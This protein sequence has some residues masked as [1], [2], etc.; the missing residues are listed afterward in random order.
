MASKRVNENQHLNTNK[1]S[2]STIS[3]PLSSSLTPLV[4]DEPVNPRDLDYTPVL[5]PDFF[6]E[7]NGNGTETEFAESVPHTAFH[8]SLLEFDFTPTTKTRDLIKFLKSLAH[9]LEQTLPD[10]LRKLYGMKA[11]L[12]VRVLYSKVDD[13]TKKIE[14]FHK[15]QP[16]IFMNLFQIREQI[17]K[18]LEQILTESAHFIRETSGNVYSDIVAAT[19]QIAHHLPLVGEQYVE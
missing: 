8:N 7:Q 11:W 3:T 1:I 2:R 14:G 13:N 19:I 17:A 4:S 10:L 12:V 15:T 5:I 6:A 9:K 18:M 16:F